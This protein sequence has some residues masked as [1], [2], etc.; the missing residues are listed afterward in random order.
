M[1]GDTRFVEF[2][3]DAATWLGSLIDAAAG[4]IDVRLTVNGSDI[5]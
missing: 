2:A 3:D 4:D 5:G 1:A